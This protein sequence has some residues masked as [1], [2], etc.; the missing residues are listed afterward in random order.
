[1]VIIGAGV[2]G[3]SVAYH[4]ARRGVRVTVIERGEIAGGTSSSCEGL[5]FLQSKKPGIHLRMALKSQEMLAVLADELPEDIEYE[6]CGGLIVFETPEEKKAMQRFVHQQK[7]SG[8]DVTL[9]DREQRDFPE[10]ALSAKL[11][12]ATYCKLDGRINPIYLTRAFIAGARRLGARIYPHCAATAIK[13]RAERVAAVSTQLGTVATARVINACGVYAPHIGQLVRL[14]IPIRPRRGQILV[15]EPLKPLIRHSLLSATYLAAK[16]DPEL[17]QSRGMGISLE[18]TARGNLLIGSTREFAG[19]DR[20][21]TSEGIRRIAR[22]IVRIV[23]TLKEVRVIRTYAGLRPYTPDGLPILGKVRALDGFLMAAGHE[24]D[25]I[26]LS[27]VTGKMI[28]DLIVEG[29]TDP[30]LAPFALER[31]PE[32]E[33]NAS[34][35]LK[36]NHGC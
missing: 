15:T 23:P 33:P 20:R 13:V 17:A 29:H 14:N 2:I 25:G 18:Q 5:I 1:M 3:A 4:L 8:L 16:Y 7:E 26:A 10:P 27:A 12:G 34:V 31:F 35:T 32:S 19:F 11:L 6:R 22:K 30:D 21:T 36:N 28:A 9:L 24:G